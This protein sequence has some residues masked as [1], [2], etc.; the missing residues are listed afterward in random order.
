MILHLLCFG[1]VCPLSKSNV[2]IRARTEDAPVACHNDALYALVD[3]EHGVCGLDLLAHRV[4]ERIVVLG[5]VQRK[6]DHRR[7]F[8]MVT[9]L[10]LREFEVV[11][12]G[13]ERDVGFV[14][15][16]LVAAGRHGWGRRC[17]LRIVGM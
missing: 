12:R 10:D 16:R 8:F 2:Q 6:N 4:C 15:G 17:E 11:V 9:R 5:P 3:V 14:A 1:T 7:L 13:R